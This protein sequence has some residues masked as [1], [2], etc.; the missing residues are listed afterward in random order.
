MVRKGCWGGEDSLAMLRCAI[1]GE[2]LWGE[3]TSLLRSFL[4][5][6]KC[7]LGRDV[8]GRALFNGSEESGKTVSIHEPAG[9]VH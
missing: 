6:L 9:S 1:C 2:R 7:V 4:Q 3:F 8:V 5:N